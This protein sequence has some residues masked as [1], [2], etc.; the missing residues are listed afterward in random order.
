LSFDKNKSLSKAQKLIQ[1][2]KVQKAI[3]EYQI[4]VDNDPSDIRT[5]LKIGDLHAKLGNI[6]AATDTYRKVAEHY[7]KDGFF[8]KAIAVFKQIL[9]LDPGVIG[10]Y[11]RLAELYNQLGLNSEAMKQYQIVVKHYENKGMKKESLDILKKMAELDPDNVASKVKLAELYI[12]EGFKD[13]A[14]S[15]FSTVAK[16]LKDKHNFEDLI[17]VLEKMV[18]LNAQDYPN[19]KELSAIYL[20]VGEPKKA[21]AKLQTCFKSNP[22]DA[23]TLELLAQAF[24]DLQ[25]PEKARSVYKELAGVY[26]ASGMIEEK[27]QII[28]KMKA[29]LPEESFQVSASSM[30]SESIA[31]PKDEEKQDLMLE[32]EA[33]ASKVPESSSKLVSEVEVYVKY[34]LLDKA[35][36]NLIR[37]LLTI[38]DKEPLLA[39]LKEIQRTDGTKTAFQKS[40]ESG[41]AKLKSSG[42]QDLVLLL[43]RGDSPKG[44]KKKIQEE[45]IVEELEEEILVG[46]DN[47]VEVGDSL[48]DGAKEPLSNVVEIDLGQESHKAESEKVQ[49]QSK[50]PLRESARGPKIEFPE[51]VSAKKAPG[52]ELVSLEISDSLEKEMLRDEKLEEPVELSVF[53]IKSGEQ[54]AEIEEAPIKPKLEPVVPKEEK[55][56]VQEVVPQPVIQEKS[57]AK[58]VQPVKVKYKDELEEA[59]FFIKQGLLDEARYIYESILEAEPDFSEAKGK[60]AEIDELVNKDARSR[61]SSKKELSVEKALDAQR[62]QPELSRDKMDSGGG[63]LFDLGKELSGEIEA[64]NKALESPKEEP[65]LTFEEMFSQ[66]KKGVEKSL[67]KDDYQAHYDLGVAYKEMGLTEDA[68]GEFRTSMLSESFKIKSLAMIGICFHE[69][70]HYENAIKTYE[71][72]LSLV[73]RDSDEGLSF[74][75]DMA[76]SHYRSGNVDAALNLLREIKGKKST[77]RNV[78]KRITEIEAASMERSKSGIAGGSEKQQGEENSAE[79]DDKDNEDSDKKN[80]ISYI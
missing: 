64:I 36:D 4:I 75:F 31:R 18:A 9:K 45:E 13:Q 55:I 25:Q 11:V 78:V 8:L 19:I 68:I 20:K 2:G 48:V 16:E 67:S 52:E 57:K 54:E 44:L 50:S 74:L 17:K 71:M 76:E 1:Q 29:M 6:E 12:K 80:K 34:G 24:V 65:A 32:E 7:A 58:A 49:V 73:G 63:D 53:E 79:K 41:L 46:D 22:K 40:M 3:E 14:V 10:I 72:G 43:T 27:E 21:L 51:D 30:S 33:P 61:V 60:I 42:H 70:G 5:L 28:E 56:K 62:Q 15:Q 69:K 77:F 59:D 38:N 37:G 26:E 35:I 47:L 23:L 66:F 39:K